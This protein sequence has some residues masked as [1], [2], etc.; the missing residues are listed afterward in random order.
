MALSSF[1]LGLNDEYLLLEFILDSTM[2]FHKHTLWKRGRK[3]KQLMT[4]SAFPPQ[5]ER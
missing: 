5:L 2:Y 3:D 4:L 1:D